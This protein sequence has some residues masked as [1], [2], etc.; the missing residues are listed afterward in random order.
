MKNSRRLRLPG[1]ALAALFSLVLSCGLTSCENID[2]Y[3]QPAVVRVIDASYTAPAVNVNLDGTLFAA[4]IAQGTFTKYGTLTA[5]SRALVSVTPEVGGANLISTNHTLLPGQRH[6]ILISDSGSTPATYNISLLD[7]QRVAAAAGH[8][9]FRFINQGIKAGGVDIYMVPSG[10]T[11]ANAVPV[12]ANLAAGSV[13]GYVTF[14]S[15][16]VNM[17]VTAAGSSNVKYTSPALNLAGGEVRTALVMD[18][19]L[20][21]NPQVTVFVGSDVN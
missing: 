7:D 14:N 3:T 13:T 16:T 6:S 11:L 19:Q 21:S 17:I 9:A 1:F 10:V 2:T 18:T 8:S 15:R 20:T 12:V 5:K 4:K